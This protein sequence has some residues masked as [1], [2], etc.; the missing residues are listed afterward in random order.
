MHTSYKDLSVAAHQLASDLRQL[1]LARINAALLQ[2]A[3]KLSPSAA[4]IPMARLQQASL[5]RTAPARPMHCI[6]DGCR[7]VRGHLY[8]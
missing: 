2:R 3:I 1:V 4:S 6:D 8:Q 7:I 5:C